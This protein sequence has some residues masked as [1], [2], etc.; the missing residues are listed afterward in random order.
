MSTNTEP[1]ENRL[2]G[3]D[4][5]EKGREPQAL[6]P[7]PREGET[8]INQIRRLVED[9]KAIGIMRA[10]A[11]KEMAQEVA[12]QP[13]DSWIISIDSE[14]DFTRDTDFR[15]GIKFPGQSFKKLLA[16]KENGEM[17]VCYGA[18]Q[19]NTSNE[20]QSARSIVYKKWHPI[21]DL[22]SSSLTRAR[23]LS[24]ADFPNK[25]LVLTTL[26]LS[27]TRFQFI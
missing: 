12:N 2:I 15:H 4:I 24:T 26:E 14:I 16:I 10:N 5:M 21:E 27:I 11:N 3:P 18:N 13:E 17:L 8:S 20:T 1:P 22:E 23:Q 25:P 19:I 9:K 7:K 6:F